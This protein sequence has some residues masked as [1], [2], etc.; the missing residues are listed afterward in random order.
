MAILIPSL[1]RAR[2]NARRVV[3]LNNLGQYQKANVFYLADWK[4]VFPPHRCKVN[5][6]AGEKGDNISEKHWFRFFEKYTKTKEVGRCPSIPASA[7]SD[8][9]DQGSLA[10]NYSYD[11]T[12][13]GYGYNAWF[14]G[15]HLYTGGKSFDI[16][17]E[18]WFKESKIKRPA[19][20]IL[21][22]DSNPAIYGS[23][24]DWSSTLWW[25]AIISQGEGVN[26]NRHLKSGN[27]FFN[28]GH[29]QNFKEGNINPKVDGSN[30]FFSCGTRWFAFDPT[31]VGNER[32]ASSSIRLT[33]LPM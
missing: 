26:T 13:I 29:G 3:C 25:P 11:R 2:E 28:D 33:D 9:S 12:N 21:Y 17:V 20:N 10:W 7:Q 8:K 18:P 23:S 4:G 16:T 27:V 31:T 14:L 15:L 24:N 5:V 32:C 1:S 22:G 6:A 19:A 30:K